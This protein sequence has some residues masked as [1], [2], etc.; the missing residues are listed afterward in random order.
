[1]LIFDL[2]FIF[3]PGTW[4]TDHFYFGLCKDSSKTHFLWQNGEALT[5]HFWRDGR[6]DNHAGIQHCGY[7][8][9]DSNHEW[10]DNPCDKNPGY[11]YICEIVMR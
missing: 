3:V 7:L 5:F 11:K 1:M 4:P 6:P 2:H 10:N 9:G 8:D